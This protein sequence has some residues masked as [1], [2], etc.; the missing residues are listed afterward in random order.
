[1][2]DPVPEAIP[3]APTALPVAA[4]G[5]V[6]AGPPVEKN[7][8]LTKAPPTGRKFPCPSC[9]A[10]LDFDPSVRGL[11]CPY[12]GFEEKIEKGADAEVHER[13][14]LDYLSREEG[15]GKALPGRS[16][17][18]RCP[19]C[20]AVV[21]LEDN[22]ATDKCPFCATH[23]E[24]RPEVA[25]AMIPPEA[26]L[27]FTKNLHSA[28]EAFDK[29]IQSLWFAPTELKDL[30]NL[31]QLSGVYVPYWTYDAMTYTFYDG[32]R[33]VNYT[34]TVMVTQRDANGREVQVPQ[35]VV[36]VQWS[37]VS[38]EVQHFFD[39]VLVCGSKSIRADQIDRVGPWDTKKLEP[40]EPEYLSGFKTERYAVG[41]KEGMQVA[42]QEMEQTIFRLICQDIG[43]DQQRVHQKQTRYSGLTFKHVLV[44]VWVAAYRYR[45]KAYQI[46]VN[47]RTGR[48]AGDRPYSAWKITRLIL[49]ILLIVALVAV[50]AMQFGKGHSTPP[51]TNNPRRAAAQSQEQLAVHRF[52]GESRSRHG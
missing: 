48:T 22:V 3:A 45:D 18:T 33:G 52:V 38:G 4:N 25:K 46:L 39:D 47:G 31:G 35:T 24:T 40:F 27:P 12:C 7:P 8:T 20:G 2:P 42:K 36:Q 16:T 37:P 29:W 1:M 34:V 28:R 41:L 15:K 32:E 50:I 5:P 6:V 21:L 17:E 51:R 49:L 26:V 14:Y 11:K 43:G 44:P 9:G 10:R 13:D 30:A 23:L 19:G